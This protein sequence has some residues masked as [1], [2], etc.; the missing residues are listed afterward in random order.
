M[1]E[2]ADA[3]DGLDASRYIEGDTAALAFGPLARPGEAALAS[4][5]PSDQPRPAGLKPERE[6]RRSRVV[7]NPEPAAFSRRSGHVAAQS[8]AAS[9]HTVST[10]SRLTT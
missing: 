7:G 4:R 10:I 6:R 9:P 2:M 5:S 8:P 3:G 1:D